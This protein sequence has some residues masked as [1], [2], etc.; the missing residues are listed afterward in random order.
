MQKFSTKIL[1]NQ[2]QQDVRKIIQKLTALCNKCAIYSLGMQ[3]EFNIWKINVTG[4]IDRIKDK[5]HTIISTNLRKEF[6]RN[7]ASLHSKIFSKVGK[8]RNFPKLINA[9]YKNL[10]ANIIQ[11]AFSFKNRKKITLLTF[12]FN[13][14]QRFY[15]GKFRQ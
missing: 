10:T 11:N 5:S 4:C 2:T 13:A 9:I 7:P 14:V 8:D 15:S 3:D 1:A 12:L 6:Y